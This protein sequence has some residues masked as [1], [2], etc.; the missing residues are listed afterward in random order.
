MV[1]LQSRLDHVEWVDEDGRNSPGG[2]AADSFYHRGREAAMLVCHLECV[3]VV[4]MTECTWVVC[5]ENR[6]KK[7]ELGAMTKA[8]RVLPRLALA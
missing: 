7:R 4:N 8:V 1:T 2:E 5:N 6:Q 3:V